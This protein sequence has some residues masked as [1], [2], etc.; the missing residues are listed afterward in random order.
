MG[1]K[2]SCEIVRDLLP[3]YMEHMTGEGTNESILEH[4]ETCGE[5]RDVYEQ[6]NNKITTE[7]APEI[8]QVKK[9][10]NRTKL[11]Y[12]LNGLVVLGILGI[13]TCFIVNAAVDRKLSWSL[14]VL[15]SVLY[16]F[17]LL[18]IFVKSK[19]NKL[20][21]TAICATILAFPFLILI[22]YV[23]YYLMHIS[24]LWIKTGLMITL[25]WCIYVWIIIGIIKLIKI[26]WWY[27]LSL[28]LFLS[29]PGNLLTNWMLGD[30]HTLNDALWNI[31]NIGGSIITGVLLAV[32]GFVNQIKKRSK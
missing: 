29:I 24:Y 8:K 11:N 27:I 14:I 19:R 22:Q 15:G 31:L 4:L 6:M 12:L 2:I 30:L 18:F 3:N 5:C 25:I 26:N 9:Y 28:M 21:K 17:A 23:I 13:V 32:I 20:C 16:A 1:E 7:T 10:M